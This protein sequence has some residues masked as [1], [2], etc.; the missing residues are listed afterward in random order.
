[1]DLKRI[2]TTIAADNILSRMVC[3]LLSRNG[4]DRLMDL[5]EHYDRFVEKLGGLANDADVDVVRHEFPDVESLKRAI[6]GIIE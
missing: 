6:A 4:N 2:L 3:E 1:M 5:L